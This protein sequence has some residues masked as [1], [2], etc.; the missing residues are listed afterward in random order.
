MSRG[1]RIV[2]A[3]DRSRYM[4]LGHVVSILQSRNSSFKFKCKF[5]Q[6]H[7]IHQRRRLQWK[8]LAG[9][10]TR[11]L[12]R[13]SHQPRQ[14]MGLLGCNKFI[15]DIHVT[16]L[17]WPESASELYRPSDHRSSTKLVPNFAY[18]GCHVVRVTE[19]DGRNLG[20]LDRSR[21]FFFQAAP[22]L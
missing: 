13:K 22:Q 15:L 6:T 18:R 14:L 1:V 11:N 3:V 9:T 2:I 4:V 7:Q 20:F 17:N 8:A 21:Y 19:P 5:K 10:G 12:T 16:K